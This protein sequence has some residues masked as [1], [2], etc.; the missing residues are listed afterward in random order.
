MTDSPVAIL[1][2]IRLPLC[3][4]CEE[5]ALFELQAKSGEKLGRFCEKHAKARLAKENMT[6]VVSR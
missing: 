4:H 3:N 2:P 6:T 1:V 5:Y